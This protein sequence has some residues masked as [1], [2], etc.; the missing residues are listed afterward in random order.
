MKR[1]PEGFND[2]QCRDLQS[3]SV[4][5]M[6]FLMCFFFVWNFLQVSKIFTKFDADGSGELSVEE[7]ES[8][9]IGGNFSL[10]NIHSISPRESRY[11]V[12]SHQNGYKEIMSDGNL[13]LL[14]AIL[15][16]RSPLSLL[17]ILREVASHVKGGV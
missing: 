5:D 1:L 10:G 12:I 4:W 11:T 7:L 16:S 8:Y 13:P 14:P 3:S 6:F 9:L 17:Y 2:I 15:S